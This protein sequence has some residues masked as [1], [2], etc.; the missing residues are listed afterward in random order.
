MESALKILLKCLLVKLSL[1]FAC[2][3]TRIADNLR[4][5]VE[6]VNVNVCYFSKVTL[7]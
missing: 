6:C 7:K 2:H 5:L 1:P 3:H 4:K